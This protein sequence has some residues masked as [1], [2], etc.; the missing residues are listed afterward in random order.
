MIYIGVNPDIAKLGP[1]TL[2]WHGVFGVIG[3]AL[4]TWLI[5]RL[6][7]SGL[8]VNKSH[9]SEV[10]LWGII[11]GL[12]GSRTVHVI[13]YWEFYS[14][15]PLTILSIY[16]GGHAIWGAILGGVITVAIYAWVK[17]Y[18]VGNLLDTGAI[19]LI[20]GQAIGRIGDI[21]NGEHLSAYTS[22]PWGFT[23]THPNSP[24]Y[25]LPAQHPAVV[26]EMLWDLAIFGLLWKLKGRIHPPG[27]LF[28]MYL[29]LYA[30]G[31][32]FLSFL[33]HDSN[34]VGLGLNQP[35]WISLTVLV[36]AVP[37]LLI[38]LRRESSKL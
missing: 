34:F 35:Q 16:E 10:L 25:G 4:A 37:W 11:G 22:L 18:P 14:A 33:R 13:D 9:L 27:S 31:R 2:S 6:D 29:S 12:V 17:R 5:F 32:F 15:N 24:S 3:G 7:R 28:L 23:Y 1:L 38:R 26:Y 20:L 19:G 8:N 21:I 36:V 30:F